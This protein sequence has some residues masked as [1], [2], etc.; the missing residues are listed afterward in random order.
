MI[1]ICVVKID[2]QSLSIEYY[3]L[4]SNVIK[5]SLDILNLYILNELLKLQIFKAN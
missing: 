4:L 5:Y 1:G 3:L 2:Y